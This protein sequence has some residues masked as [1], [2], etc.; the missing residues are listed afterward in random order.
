MSA[1][2]ACAPDSLGAR[3]LQS[4]RVC[5]VWPFFHA[6]DAC[7]SAFKD[8]Q[9]AGLLTLTPMYLLLGCALPVWLH[10][11]GE[12]ASLATLSGVIS[13]GVG[14]AAASLVGSYGRMRWSGSRKTLEGSCAAWVA[15]LVASLLL[16]S[17]LHSHLTISAGE[18]LVLALISA[19][20]A[21]AEAR[22]PDIDNLVLPLVHYSLTLVARVKSCRF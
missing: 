18:L 21:V 9:D 17:F 12:G 11:S 20:V 19:V 1:A 8:E 5:R 16:W 22:T 3:R 2:I 6:L 13:V 15:Q 10:P 4:L 7:V 14:D